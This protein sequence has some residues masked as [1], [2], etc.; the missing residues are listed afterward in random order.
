MLSSLLAV[1]AAA[2]AILADA[3]ATQAPTPVAPATVT[4]SAPAQ[5]P[6]QKVVCRKYTATGSLLDSQRICHTVA[7]WRQISRDARDN[8]ES[9]TRQGLSISESPTLA[10]GGH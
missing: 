10:A 1:S 4:T 3:P 2:V 8:I 7:D 9:S 6:D 5:D